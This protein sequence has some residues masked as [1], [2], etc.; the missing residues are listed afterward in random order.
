MGIWGDVNLEAAEVRAFCQEID[1]VIL[2]FQ[3]LS[4]DDHV[5]EPFSLV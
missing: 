3:L 4:W 5:T 1:E 2:T